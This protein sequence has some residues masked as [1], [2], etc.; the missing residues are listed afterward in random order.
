MEIV[1]SAMAAGLSAI[2]FLIGFSSIRLRAERER[3][4]SRSDGISVEL[5]QSASQGRAVNDQ[6]IMS[7]AKALKDAKTHDPIGILTLVGTILLTMGTIVIG[8]WA[9]LRNGL[10]ITLDASQWSIDG[11]ATLYLS[12]AT[13]IVVILGIIDYRWVHTDLQ[14]R[15][16]NSPAGRANNALEKLN[17][18]QLDE[19]E[20]ISNYLASEHPTWP[21]TYAFQAQLSSKRGKYPQAI[22]TLAKALALDP[23]NDWW[24]FAKAELLLASNSFTE[25]LALCDD[26][27]SGA[28]SSA[29][30]SNVRASALYGLGKRDEAVAEFNNAIGLDPDNPTMRAHRARALLDA[31]GR[32]TELA[33]TDGLASILLDD[34]ERIAIKAVTRAG[35]EHLRSL[36]TSAAIEDLTFAIER[37]PDNGEAYL[38]RATSYYY[39][40]QIDLAEE[41]FIRALSCGVKPNRV[42]QQRARGFAYLGD[43]AGAIKELSNAIAA[44]ASPDNFYRR[45]M[46]YRSTGEHELA[47]SDFDKSITI[48]ADNLHAMVHRAQTLGS[49]NRLAECDAAFRGA[50]EVD[51]SSMHTYEVWLQTMLAVTEIGSLGEVIS[52]AREHVQD[53]TSLV[54]VL[55]LA[56]SVSAKQKLYNQAMKLLDEAERIEPLSPPVAYRRAVCLASMGEY[57]E[58]EKAISPALNS[59]WGM[60]FAAYATRSTLRRNQKNWEGALLDIREAIKLEPGEARLLVSRACLVMS[61][62]EYGPAAKD[63]DRALAIDPRSSSAL[64]HR[65]RLRVETNDLPGAHADLGSLKTLIGADSRLWLVAGD[66]YYSRKQDWERVAECRRKLLQKNPDGTEELWALAAAYINWDRPRDAEELFKLLVRRDPESMEYGLSLSVSI[67]MQGRSEEAI[68]EFSKMSLSFGTEAETWMTTHL[69]ADLLPRHDVVMAD[70]RSSTDD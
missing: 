1:T 20:G 67:S 59:A 57:A 12:V 66:H 26:I 44:E 63:L 29:A 53:E 41:D 11:M 19:A 69:S 64:W 52:L 25:C 18:D 49:L 39:D 9:S 28:I 50:A 3:A 42:L 10:H 68:Q 36:D 62:R 70:W 34:G 47:L 61:R 14:A 32:D 4:L 30:L 24:K 51:L 37:D 56:A 5:T 58:A 35:R 7:A 6:Q 65:V 46:V 48:D 38:W 43:T 21:W 22:D 45:A 16:E 13:T 23:S 15:I 27:N 40:K 17:S 31:N 55:A 33:P 54:P 8:L 60:R 2:A